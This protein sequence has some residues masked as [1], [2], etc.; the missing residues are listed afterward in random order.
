M[1][2]TLLL[3]AQWE[4]TSGPMGGYV[5]S[6][7]WDGECVYAATGGGVL[8]SE[9][10]G[11][12]W[13]FRNAGLSSC[14]TKSLVLLGDYIF[15][16]GDENVFRSSDQGM[17]WEA[18]GS[19]MAGKYTKTLVVCNDVIFAGTYLYEIYRSEITGQP[20]LW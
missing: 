2:L 19:E 7:A 12:S 17:N 8:V 11:L 10:E 16:S 1:S 14:D 6:I 9:N 18:A 13:E 5:R 4:E 20:G 15:V 3:S